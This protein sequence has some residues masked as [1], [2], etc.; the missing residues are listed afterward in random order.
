MERH[1][2]IV[3]VLKER[4]ITRLHSSRLGARIAKSRV[5]LEHVPKVEI[6]SSTHVASDEH[7]RISPSNGRQI[8][9]GITLVTN[10]QS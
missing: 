1:V 8:P 7:S 9:F 3:T 4:S 10:E 2:R 6:R 5:H